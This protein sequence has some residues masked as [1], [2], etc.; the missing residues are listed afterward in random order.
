MTSSFQLRRASIRL[1]TPL[2]L[3]PAALLLAA[4]ATTT[5]PTAPVGTQKMPEP[6]KSV[7]QPA[8][9]TPQELTLQAMV[10]MQDR[11]YRV[12]APLLVNNTELCKSVAR[13]L[14]G[15]TAKNKYSYSQDYAAAAQ[16]VLGLGDR[17][18]VTGVLEGSG[19]MRAGVQRGDILLSIENQN[20]PQGE[21]AES[22]AATVLAPLMTGRTS[23]KLNVLR[24]GNT[25]SLNVPLTYACAFGVELGNTDNVTAYAD[26]HRVLITRGMLKVLQSDD[27]LAYVLAKEMAH[28]VLA[29]PKRLRMSATIGGIIDNLT[30]MQPDMSTMV[31][32]G[33]VKPVPQDLDV[34]ADRL[35]LYMLARAGY[36]LDGA[37]PFW[38]RMASQYPASMLNTYTAIHPSTNYRMTV[39]QRTLRDIKAKQNAKKPLMP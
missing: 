10:P 26:G 29:H 15:F 18:Q 21:N 37:V 28:N 19:A 25:V 12:A 7:V 27:E 11:L 38:Q 23:V 20:L 8:Q 33:G 3:I 5:E 31:G 24:N 30:R 35:S 4:C 32:L 6:V 2:L 16:K 36:S 39:M 1:R 13:N 22:Q 17:L 9:P 34:I 14:L